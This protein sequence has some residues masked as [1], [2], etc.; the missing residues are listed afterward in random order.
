MQQTSWEGSLQKGATK[1]SSV[2]DYW[3]RDPVGET[4]NPLHVA[5]GALVELAGTCL[6]AF[7]WGA[8]AGAQVNDVARVS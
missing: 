6:E 4:R 5:R 3:I 7:Q 1:C 2:V 8:P